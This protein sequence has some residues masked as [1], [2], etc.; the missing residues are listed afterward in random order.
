[1][2]CASAT[3]SAASLRG[4]LLSAG[5]AWLLASRVFKVPFDTWHWPLAGA[6][7]LVCAITAGLGMLLSRGVVSHPPLAVLRGE[8]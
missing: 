4:A 7:A 5:F 8:G 2:R 6:V 3:G 1:M